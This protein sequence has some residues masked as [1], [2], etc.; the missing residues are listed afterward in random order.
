M[1]LR[2]MR[3][4]TGN[5]VSGTKL[6]SRPGSERESRPFRVRR[7]RPTLKVVVGPGRPRA[8]P[9]LTLQLAPAP[10]T[11]PH[12]VPAAD[13][14]LGAQRSSGLQRSDAHDP[15]ATRMELP[16]VCGTAFLIPQ[17]WFA[18]ITKLMR[19]RPVPP[20]R[21]ADVSGVV[22]GRVDGRDRPSGP[23]T[24]RGGALRWYRSGA[25]EGRRHGPLTARLP[26]TAPVR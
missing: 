8:Q 10:E 22:E 24:I 5:P 25:G 16:G 26:A 7:I 12:D 9:R 19:Q 17:Q 2:R 4:F 6:P 1:R 11:R 21:G 20:I 3:R 14:A 15:R 13:R 18:I 23:A